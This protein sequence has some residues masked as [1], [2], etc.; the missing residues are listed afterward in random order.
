MKRRKKD[1][2]NFTPLTETEFSQS[3]G[4][5]EIITLWDQLPYYIQTDKLRNQIRAIFGEDILMKLLSNIKQ[6]G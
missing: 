5:F 4:L 3:A 2:S 1:I 6:I